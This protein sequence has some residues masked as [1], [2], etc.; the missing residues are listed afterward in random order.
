M[1]KTEKTF[2]RWI[3]LLGGLLGSITCG[4]LLYAFSVFIR[5]L[6]VQFG[7]TVP[8]V[9]LA[10]SLIC[11]VLG[12]MTLPAGRLSDKFGPR[13]VVLMGGIVM[14]LGFFLVSTI[15]PPDPALL[16]GDGATQST[17]K[18][19][20]YLLYIYYG[21][22][23]GFGG[24]CVYLPPIATAPKW[25]P[26]KRAL[27][28][29]FAVVG[30]G[31][32][33]FVMAPVSTSMINHFGSALPVFKYMGIAMGVI[34][35]FAAMCL[36]EPPKGYKPA[37]WN[38]PQTSSE[39]VPQN[40]RD[41]THEETRK[42]PQ[43]WLLWLTYF[44]GSFAGLM[45]IGLIAKHG[46]DAMTIAYAAREGID[47][48]TAVPDDVAKNIAM[49]ASFAAS[50][51]AVFNAA[52]RILIGPL[53][54]R[55]GTKKIFVT[56]F[57]IQTVAMLFLFP[58]GK[59][60]ALL[61]ACAGLIGWNYGSIFTL[62]PAT[63]LQY[64]GPTNQAS[65]YGLLFSAFGFAGFCGPYIGGKLQAMTGSFFAPFL[66]SSVVLAISVAI[67]A[68]LKAPKKIPV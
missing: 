34:V 43:F 17:S 62:F 54:D 22:I 58:A 32:G 37:G 10:Y 1:S 14:A 30:I 18:L 50:A 4:M 19:P 68:T 40:Y 48:L 21:I 38:P 15:T 61:A 55:V 13:K 3:P 59:S 23:A 56:L 2:P 46:I 67:L 5:P 49:S 36:K 11:L 63:L 20:L 7:W 24:A 60:A 28:T 26:D 45:V 33:S 52:V 35:V 41:Y 39:G 27:A 51:L 16:T 65:N 66:V 8:E 9:T 6:Q 29:G 44:G 31:L 57:A 64:Y 25:W 42:T 47:A 12:L 53:A